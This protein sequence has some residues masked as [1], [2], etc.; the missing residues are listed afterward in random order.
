[1]KLTSAAAA[2]GLMLVVASGCA[3][4][5][6][7]G[8]AVQDPDAAVSFSGYAL[9]PR[10]RVELESRN[11]GGTFE[12]FATTRAE[13]S[14]LVLDDGTRLY[15][16]DVAAVVPHWHGS[17][18]DSAAEVRA[19]G[20]VGRIRKPLFTFDESG[21][22]C[23]NNALNAG[24]PFM[25]AAETCAAELNSSLQLRAGAGTITGDVQITT[26]AEADALACATIIDGNL[27]VRPAAP[28][29]SLPN[30]QQ[31]TGNVLIE[32]EDPGPSF[33]TAEQA[34]LPALHTIG[35]NLQFH[36]LD[37]AY[38]VTV[39]LGLPA[40]T[41]LAGDMEL[42]LSSFNGQNSGPANL[43]TVAGNVSI[44][45][46]GDFYGGSMLTSL[47]SVGGNLAVATTGAGSSGAIL[48]GLESVGG[49]L[50][51]DRLRFLRDPVF[52]GLQ[53]VGGGM[54]LTNCSW[55]V[56][57]FPALGTI[58]GTLRVEN[59]SDGSAP[60]GAPVIGSASL[61][62]G[63]VELV[64]SFLATMPF[65]AAATVA[66]SGDITIVDNAHL[67]QTSVDAFVTAQQ[68]AGWSGTLTV[69]NNT[70]SCSP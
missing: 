24:T 41:S 59:P 13:S 70:G 55:A 17:G 14:P 22:Q 2:A 68:A 25:Q 35:G 38:G 30:L 26:Q 69:S 33:S 37:G 16:W 45:A 27:T 65:P 11:A 34:D 19:V 6:P 4:L 21:A 36:H 42:L 23:V 66:T 61:S 1:M 20:V 3:V 9:L 32:V 62:M 58:G 46:S 5:E 53:S 7:G 56:A 18:C 40:L 52:T 43:Q 67:C 31:V 44:M 39:N 63:G 57:R 29:V 28:V 60:P 15:P 49:N 47:Q 64:T 54:T 50:T 12:T 8:G 10:Q 51:I 48:N